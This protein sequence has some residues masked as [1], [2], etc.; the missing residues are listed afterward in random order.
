MRIQCNMVNQ[1]ALLH[2]KLQ[3]CQVSHNYSSALSAALYLEDKKKTIHT[4]HLWI[5]IIE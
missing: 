3:T 2:F 5:W 4:K 1:R